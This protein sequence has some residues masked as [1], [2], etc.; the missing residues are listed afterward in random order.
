MVSK[1]SAEIE[2]RSTALGMWETLWLM[3][4]QEEIVVKVLPLMVIHC[5]KK[6]AI[7]TSHNP[8][9]YDHTKHIEVDRQFI[10]EDRWSN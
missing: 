2:L 8:V 4:L 10:Q 5:D 6:V 7:S 9:H 1:S 3:M